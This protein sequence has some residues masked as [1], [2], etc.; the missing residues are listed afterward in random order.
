MIITNGP[1]GKVIALNADGREP[2]FSG[3][4]GLV[5]PADAAPLLAGAISHQPATLTITGTP[6]R[7][8]AFNIVGKLDRGKKEWII[9][10]T[11]RSGWFGCAGERGGGIAAW[12][13]LARW[14]PEALPDHNIAF[15]CN[16]GHE[17]EYLAHKKR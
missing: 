1:T 14:S 9:V 2:M 11:P 6:G 10:S 15:L 3:P 4:V 8:E 7:R 12:L 5:A 17:Y 13:D 16:S